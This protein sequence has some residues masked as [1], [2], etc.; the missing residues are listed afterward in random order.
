MLKQ[1]NLLLLE[2]EPLMRMMMAS[3][4]EEAG[5]LVQDVGSCAEARDWA[6]SRRYDLFLFDHRLPDG[7]CL[8]LLMELREAGIIT[9]V[10]ILSGEANRVADEAKHIA[11]I[12]AVLTKPPDMNQLISSIE[13][14]VMD[15]RSVASN[16]ARIGRYR[17][18][19]PAEYIRLSEEACREWLVL[20]LRASELTQLSPELLCRVE[21]AGCRIAALGARTELAAQ[22]RTHNQDIELAA[23]EAELAAIS[24]H[25]T[26]SAE[27]AALMHTA[28]QHDRRPEDA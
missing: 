25:G 22:L 9:P 15:G 23:D 17:C 2:D 4:L 10:L 21:A 8:E 18:V 11:H 20:D 14:G 5:A 6:M 13:Q 24:R 3:A 12:V 26:S 28:I 27:R 7:T 1:I 16:R 19:S